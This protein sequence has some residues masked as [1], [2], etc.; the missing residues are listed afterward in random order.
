MNFANG[1]MIWKHMEDEMEDDNFNGGGGQ[2]WIDHLNGSFVVGEKRVGG[3]TGAP[4]S[5]Y[6]F[7]ELATTRFL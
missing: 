3:W 4:T 7:R 2:L 1:Q 5:S 6:R